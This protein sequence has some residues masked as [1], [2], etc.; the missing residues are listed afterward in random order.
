MYKVKIVVGSNGY[1]VI[2]EVWRFSILF[3]F[4]SFELIKRSKGSREEGDSFVSYEVAV[5]E[6]GFYCELMVFRY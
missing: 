3:F 1:W 2:L 5:G 6:R 4:L